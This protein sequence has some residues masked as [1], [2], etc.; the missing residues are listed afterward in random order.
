MDGFAVAS[1]D[2]TIAKDTIARIGAKSQVPLN[3]LG[4]IANFH[5][6]DVLQTQSH[7][8]I[9]CQTY[10]DKVLDG[11][12]WQEWEPGVKPIPMPND[13]VY[14]AAMETS[15]PPSNPGKKK[16]LHDTHF[17]YRRVIGEAIMPWPH[18]AQI[19]VLL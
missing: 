7:I 17:N 16:E 18:V 6:I 19:S 11:H 15:I 2:P 4:V 10:L 1:K 8:K 14:Q 12:K 3:H 13:S 9:F 5:D